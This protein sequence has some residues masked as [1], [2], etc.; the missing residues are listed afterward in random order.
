MAPLKTVMVTSYDQKTKKLI[1]IKGSKE[2]K[3]VV[4]LE[5]FVVFDLFYEVLPWAGY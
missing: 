3:G 5:V 4:V 1:L 2:V